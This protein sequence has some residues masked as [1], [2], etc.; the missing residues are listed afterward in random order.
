[1]TVRREDIEKFL[2]VLAMWA[3]MSH[4]QSIGA[5]EICCEPFRGP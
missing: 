5:L 2:P 1:M 3:G 4:E